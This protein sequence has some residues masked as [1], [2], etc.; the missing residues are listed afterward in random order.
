M[1]AC[2]SF[3][4]VFFA[5]DG[6]SFSGDCLGRLATRLTLTAAGV[7]SE[8][9]NK[10]SASEKRRAMRAAWTK[11]EKRKEIFKGRDFLFLRFEVLFLILSF[12]W[13]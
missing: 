4:A 11:S 3:F 13:V 12:F 9:Y 5:G 8:E 1:V 2:C 7:L 6:V 10:A